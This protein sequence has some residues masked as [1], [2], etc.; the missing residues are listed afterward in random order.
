M[1]QQDE[2]SSV[3]PTEF[4]STVLIVPGLRDHVHDHWQTLLAA[5]LP[6]VR[7]VPPLETD[8]LNCQAR[9][10]AIQQTLDD[11]TGPVILVAHSAGVLMV[12]H[13]AARYRR[14][15][16]GALLVTPPDLDTQ[17]PE[18]YP[19]P[20][21]LRTNGWTPLPR[22]PLPFFS[23]VAASTNDHLAS[24]DAVAAL[25]RDWRAELV[26]LG[27]VGHLNPASGYGLWP[28]AES[29]IRLLEQS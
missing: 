4:P 5:R 23:L 3:T 15:I 25:A 7:I 12:A 8:K 28:Q 24:I 29:F 14:A 16:K 18:Q 6:R 10:D 26:N 13:W 2:V 1:T 19:A 9:V 20:E 11:I 27:A 22:Q 21:T 17:W